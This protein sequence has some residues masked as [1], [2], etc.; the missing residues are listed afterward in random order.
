[1]VED[2]C[3]A[4]VGP[5]TEPFWV[6]VAA[7]RRYVEGEGRGLLP[8]EGSI[9]DM[10][11]ST[12]LYLDLQRLY[13]DKAEADVDAGA[14]GGG[15]GSGGG[16]GGAHSGG[17][18]LFNFCHQG[19]LGR[20]VV[21]EGRGPGAGWAP[22]GTPWRPAVERHARALLEAAGRDPA[23]IPRAEVKHF[24]KHARYLR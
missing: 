1:M 21:E 6:L 24:C 12:Q 2:E 7:L 23:S 13:R 11:A 20:A 4:S 9:P 10:H 8:L 15:G 19:R 3:A 17:A 14:R 18:S 5:Q 22:D 16:S